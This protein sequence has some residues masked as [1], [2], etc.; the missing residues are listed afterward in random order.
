M[1]TY[2]EA[3]AVGPLAATGHVQARVA[4]T[5]AQ[6]MVDPALLAQVTADDVALAEHLA[7]TSG[8]VGQALLAVAIARMA[9]VPI[10]SQQL[11][12]L[13]GTGMPIIVADDTS[14]DAAFGAAPFAVTTRQ[15][16]PRIVMPVSTLANEASGA[17]ALAHESVHATNL[18]RGIQQPHE[19]AFAVGSQVRVELG[20]PRA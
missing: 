17:P 7:P 1:T 3:G 10:G 18:A 15:P 9:S 20:L 8:P 11:A 4:D 2:T 6:P 19:V 16:S 14:F 13:V 12:A 5:R